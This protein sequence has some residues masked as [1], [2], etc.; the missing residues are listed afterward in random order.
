[1]SDVYLTITFQ[2]LCVVWLPA[3]SGNFWVRLRKNRMRRRFPMPMN[4]SKSNASVGRTTPARWQGSR[5]TAAMAGYRDDRWTALRHPML[6]PQLAPIAGELNT[7]EDTGSATR[8]FD[9]N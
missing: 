5:V 3:L 9:A 1:M 8:P 2:A 7:T 6:S 4:R